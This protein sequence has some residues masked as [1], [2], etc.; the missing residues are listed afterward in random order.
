MKTAY[1]ILGI[2]AGADDEAVKQAYLNMIRR[3]PPERAPEQFE[4][5]R[6]AYEAVK[7]SQDRAAYY[8][9]ATP[10][11]DVA[12]ALASCLPLSAPRR[13]SADQLLEALAASGKRSN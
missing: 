1:D 9:F 2:E 12:A 13:P 10:E 4:S 5:I 6:K 8:L 3:Y 11:I 7:T